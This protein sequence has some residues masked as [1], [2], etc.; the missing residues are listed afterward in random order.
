MRF[1]RQFGLMVCWLLMSA[2]TV[3]GADVA[4]I[5]QIAS[6]VHV[7]F[8]QLVKVKKVQLPVAVSQQRAFL[9]HFPN[10]G[11]CSS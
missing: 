5:T 8:N 11:K 6:K 3:W 4:R 1:T 2:G 10:F 9:L 7:D